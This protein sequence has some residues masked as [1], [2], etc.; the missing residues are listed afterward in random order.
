[1][2]N[3]MVLQWNGRWYGELVRLR[4]SRNNTTVILISNIMRLRCSPL[5]LADLAAL[6]RFPELIP[7]LAA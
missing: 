5:D 4:C 3:A 7:G 2:S 1:M 6:R